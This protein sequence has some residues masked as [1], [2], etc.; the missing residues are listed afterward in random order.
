MDKFCLTKRQCKQLLDNELFGILDESEDDPDLIA[1]I[2]RARDY[3]EIEIVVF[4]YFISKLLEQYQKKDASKC[5]KVI[6]YISEIDKKMFATLEEFDSKFI[7]LM[8]TR[9]MPSKLNT[10][11]EDLLEIRNSFHG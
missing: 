5:N 7:D 1:I 11:E 6:E 9:S 4:N 8:M 3:Y 2:E 10:L